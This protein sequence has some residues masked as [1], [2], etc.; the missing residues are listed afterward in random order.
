MSFSYKDAHS[1]LDTLLVFGIKLGLRNME[2]LCRLLGEP[3]KSLK[4][5]H[6][7][8][9][10]GKGSSCTMLAAGLKNSG[11]TVGFYSSPF[12]CNFTERWRVNGEEVTEVEVAAAIE[13][14]VEVEELLV[15]KIGDKPT[16]FEVLTA[17]A[18][19]IFKER[20]VDIVVW[21]TGMGGRL[22]ATNVVRP[23]VSLITNI[24]LDHTQYLGDTI[25]AVAQ[26]KAGII[27]GGVPLVV[28]D[29]CASARGIFDE[30]VAKKNSQAFFSGVDFFVEDLGLVKSNGLL[31]RSV[32]YKSSDHDLDL[33]LSMAGKYQVQNVGPV[34]RV[35]EMT[36]KIFDVDFDLA[37]RGVERAVWPGRFELKS[38]NL[39][40]DGAHNV[41]AI[42]VLLDSLKELY[43]RL[44]FNF[45]CGILADKDWQR[46]LDLLQPVAQS[47]YM[48]AIDNV[49]SSQPK[50][51]EKYA[52][53]RGGLV[54]GVG[55]AR[56][57]LSGRDEGVVTVVLGS[58]YLIGEALT[59]LNDGKAL[60]IERI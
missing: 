2:V 19:L 39:I 9:T 5:I 13:Q 15:A 50:L 58:L 44:K 40:L 36:S 7:A 49:R 56:E 51:L 18:L 32:N 25:E 29:V 16:Y 34:L 55:S 42:L 20:K 23:L 30:S 37:C 14:V 10:N 12:L 41:E 24:S 48:V 38:K 6:V 60:E 47:F 45:I 28:G 54:S 33:S 57:A 46:I 27:K 35:L 3:E 11:L 59:I 1:Y 4:F 22:D 43:P 21:E 52:L 8:G 26:E 53:S 31:T 17:A